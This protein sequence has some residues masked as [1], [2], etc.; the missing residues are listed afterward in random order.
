MGS[1]PTDVKRGGLGWG[2]DDHRTKQVVKWPFKKG[3][4]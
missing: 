3:Q 4:R 2:L 1:D